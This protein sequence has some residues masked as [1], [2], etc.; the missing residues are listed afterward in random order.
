MEGSGI[1]LLGIKHNNEF[2]DRVCVKTEGN[3]RWQTSHRHLQG[4]ER[5]PEGVQVVEVVDFSC[6]RL[7]IPWKSWFIVFWFS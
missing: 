5:Q 6:Q 7:S 2:A 1:L 4:V 3:F